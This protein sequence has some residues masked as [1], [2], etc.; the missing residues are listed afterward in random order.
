MA[1]KSSA[2]ACEVGKCLCI[3]SHSFLSHYLLITKCSSESDSS[4]WG[5]D[6][7]VPSNH[8]SNAHFQLKGGKELDVGAEPN[9]K[10]SDLQGGHSQV[11]KYLLHALPLHL[12]VL[13]L[14]S[15]ISMNVTEA[16]PPPTFAC[17]SAPEKWP[18]AGTV[19]CLGQP[20]SVGRLCCSV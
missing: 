14:Q 19:C 12:L 10:H 7:K 15:T 1:G 11:R 4:V 13:V 20:G 8:F 5:N 9:I 17:S 3:R 18:F 16:H 2:H 6:F